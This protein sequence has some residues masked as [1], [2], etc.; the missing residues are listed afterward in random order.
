MLDLVAP[1]FKEVVCVFMYFVK[2]LEHTDKFLRFAK[3]R[4][5]NVTI[6]QVPHWN[7]THI[8]KSGFYCEERPEIRLKLL[9]DIVSDV[10]ERT[11][12]QYSFLGMKMSDS[13]N[14]RI[15]LRGY[16]LQAINEKSGMVYPLSVW[17]N[18]DVKNYIKSKG[19]PRPIEYTNKKRSQGMGLDIDVFLYLRENYPD[20]LKKIIKAFPLSESILFEYDQ[21]QR[22]KN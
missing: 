9:K 18:T 20:D 7:L 10:K 8:Y 11:G 12:L 19:L 1:R 22:A 21:K 17:S 16:E 3:L 14:R 4:Y 5:P 2:D 15:M 13:M 6:M